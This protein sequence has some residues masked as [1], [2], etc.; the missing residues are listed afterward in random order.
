MG[1]YDEAAG[2]TQAAMQMLPEDKWGVVIANYT[3]LYGNIQDYTDQLKALEKARDAKPD[4]PALHFLLGFHFG[5]LNYPKQ[6]VKE[7]DKALTMAPKDLGARRCGTSSRRSGPRPRR[8]RRPRSKRPRKQQ[9]RTLLRRH[10][11]RPTHPKRWRRAR[12]ARRVVRRCRTGFPVGTRL[13]QQGLSADQKLWTHVATPLHA[14]ECAMVLSFSPLTGQPRDFTGNRDGSISPGWGEGENISFTA[15]SAGAYNGRK[16]WH[17]RRLRFRFAAPTRS[18]PLSVFLGVSSGGQ[19]T[20]TR[21]T[22]VQTRAYAAGGRQFEPTS[23]SRFLF[24][25]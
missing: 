19:R 23:F 7:L 11:P 12:R 4:S 20:G 22:R 3:H 2:A 9:P 13:F 5:Y 16:P 15:F 17:P 6:A 14:L 25:E 18:W 24:Q 1:R 10:L 8:C 21:R